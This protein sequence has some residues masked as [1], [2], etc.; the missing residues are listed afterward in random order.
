M[1]LS[2]RAFSPPKVPFERIPAS[3]D[4]ADVSADTATGSRDAAGVCQT[5]LGNMQNK[6]TFRR[7]FGEY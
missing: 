4:G 5:T 1:G 2:E 6:I 7:K 3:D